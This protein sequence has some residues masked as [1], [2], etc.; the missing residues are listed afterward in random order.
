MGSRGSMNHRLPSSSSRFGSRVSFLMLSMFAT[1]ASVYVAGRL[2][3]DAENRVNLVNELD[4][5]TGQGKS[6]VSVKGTLKIIAC[7]ENQK[8]LD[9][10]HVDLEK[11]KQE[12]FVTKHLTDGT[13]KKKL[14]AVI[15][16]ITMFGRK[17]NRDA[18]RKA[19]MP[20]GIRSCMNNLSL[21]HFL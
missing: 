16:I 9:A 19:W 15:G 20:T 4:K 5:R 2:W 14:L 7:R 8:K 1:M 11:A 3:Q 21:F 12:G 10:L 17:N 13:S 6:S 18:I